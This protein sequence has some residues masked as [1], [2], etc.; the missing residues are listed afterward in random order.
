M[1]QAF[2]SAPL[3]LPFPLP[4]PPPHLLRVL[5][6]RDTDSRIPQ[7]KAGVL[8]LP[9]SSATLTTNG[10]SGPHLCNGDNLAKSCGE[11]ETLYKN[12]EQAQSLPTPLLAI[13]SALAAGGVTP[14][15]P[16][17]PAVRSVTHQGIV[18]LCSSGC[19][20]CTVTLPRAGPRLSSQDLQRPAQACT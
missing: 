5:C 12:P 20:R 9:P 2:T 18:T 13:V 1:Q 7:A 15:W 8:L 10:A 14:L 17:F 19:P 16:V 11:N 4:A 3:P 6:A